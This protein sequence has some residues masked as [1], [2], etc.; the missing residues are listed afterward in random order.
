[1]APED[2]FVLCVQ[3]PHAAR[4]FLMGTRVSVESS[5]AFDK[6]YTLVSDN[7]ER[8]PQCPWVPETL[9]FFIDVCL[10]CL[11]PLDFTPQSRRD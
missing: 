6:G 9:Y 4:G 5:L 11:A 10:V 8:I 1:M 7:Q 2:L 3:L